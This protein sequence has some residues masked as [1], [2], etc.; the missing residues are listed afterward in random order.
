MKL[1]PALVIAALLAACSSGSSTPHSSNSSSS[2]ASSAPALTAS[3]QQ[4]PSGVQEITLSNASKTLK[5]YVLADDMVYLSYFTNNPVPAFDQLFSEMIANRDFHG[6]AA[7]SQTGNSFASAQLQIAVDNNF[8]V[9]LSDSAQ[10]PLNK[11]C[12]TLI[13]DS[14]FTL[15]ISAPQTTQAYGLGEQFFD[16]GTNGDWLGRKRTPGIATGNRMVDFN[17]GQVG[18]LQI[19]L[20]L[21]SQPSKTLGYFL[22]SPHAQSWD[23]SSNTWSI[24]GYSNHFGLFMFAKADFNSARQA[25]MQ[26]TGTPP[27][28]PKTAFGLWV[29]EFG[30]DNW[31]EAETKITAQ[32]TAGMPLD[33]LVFDL[34][35]FGGIINHRMGSLSW[36]TSNFP[37]PAGKLKSWKDNYGVDAVTIEESYIDSQTS[38]YTHLNNLGYLVHSCQGCGSSFFNEWWGAGGMLDWSNKEAASYWHH[39]KRTPLINAGVVGHWTD[40]GEP[41]NFDPKGW[42]ADSYNNLRHDHAS[43]HN[44]YNFYWSKSIYDGYRSEQP[45]Q[46]PWILSR[47]GTA[48]SQRFGTSFWSGDIGSNSNSLA[49]HLQAQMHMSMSGYDYFGSDVGGFHRGNISASD[50]KPLYTLWFANSALFDIPLRPHTENLCNCKETAPALTGDI[51]SNKFN[52]QLRYRLFPYYYSL[53]HQAYRTGTAIFPPLAYYN[54]QDA[55][56]RGIGDMKYI[57]A[58]LLARAFATPSDAASLPSYIPAGNWLDWHNQRW[59]ASSG[60][61]LNLSGSFNGLTTLPLLAKEG[62]IIPMM[63]VDDQTMNLKGQRA[64]HSSHSELLLRVLASSS[65][66]QFTLYEDDGQSMAYQSGA[67]AETLISQQASDGDYL[68]TIAP[69]TGSYTG[70]PG[71][72]PYQLELFARNGAIAKVYLNDIALPI[73]SSQT[74]YDSLPQAALKLDGG[75]WLAKSDNLSLSSAKAF[76]FSEH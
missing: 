71:S 50:F 65:A 44:L 53:A 17:G 60:Q 21:T 68:V 67:V 5:L 51:A 13:S 63:Y 74:E 46:R 52:L 4:L 8:C 19:P 16:A 25:Y 12:P 9:S 62:A 73:A 29:S 66:S 48:G 33:G 39:S 2:A 1:F 75:H 69:T 59:I 72:R 38:D 24:N 47:S 58:S 26:L 23:L 22:D 20:L 41:E 64:D 34:Q 56:A 54:Q 61:S 27:V 7:L 6:A 30:F 57:G 32:R 43:I 31:A 15:A 49:A 10:Q 55:N 28:P 42:Y 40:L 37:N 3:M 11:T 70:M 14:Q 35:W 76:R 45:N 18:N 36:D